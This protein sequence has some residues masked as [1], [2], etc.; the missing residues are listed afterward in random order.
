MADD[1][2]VD[3]FCKVKEWAA[4]TIGDALGNLADSVM[5]AFGKAIGALGT[6]WVKIGTPNLTGGAS[7]VVPVGVGDVGV[8]G[9]M[10]V[11]AVVVPVSSGA[12]VPVTVGVTVSVITAVVPVAVGVTVAATVVAVAVAVVVASP[13]GTV[14]V[15]VSVSA[16]PA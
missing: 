13:A 11:V 5:E 7:V 14:A 6:V 4:S 8:V 1:C 2:G 15:G 10:V 12:I 16:G 9:V 3:P